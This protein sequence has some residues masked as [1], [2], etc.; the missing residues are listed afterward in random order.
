MTERQIMQAAFEHRDCGAVPYHLTMEDSVADKLTAY[1]G[2]EEW[3]N[4]IKDYVFGVMHVDTIMEREL[5]GVYGI[6]AFGSIWRRDKRPWHLEKPILPEPGFEGYQFPE[7][8]KFLDPLERGNA[9]EKANRAME[10]NPDKFGIIHMGWG[11]FEQTWRMRG[12]ENALMDVCCEE[13]FYEELIG[14]LTELY[15][16]M[17][18]YCK[19]VKADAFFFGDD[20]GDQRGIIIGPE[21]WRRFIKPAW[22][23]VY[24]EVHK[25]GKYVIAHSCGSVADVIGDAAEIGLDMLESVQPEANGMNPY[26]LKAKWGDKMGFFGCLGSQSTI[27]FGTPEEVRTE[28]RKLRREMGKNGGYILAPAKPLQPETPVENAAAILETFTELDKT[29]EQI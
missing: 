6:D 23:Q 27:P 29:Y 13:E 14:R 11:I 15:V 12:F 16:G 5:D 20:W 24:D 10:E 19:D 1:Y 28:I 8:S 9:I 18:R 17:V 21:R 25:Q 4:K 26:E 22:K 7:L 3:K 2:T